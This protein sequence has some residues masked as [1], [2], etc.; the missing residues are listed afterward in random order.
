MLGMQTATA[1]PE[2]IPACPEGTTFNRGFCESEPTIT[3]GAC[4]DGTLQTINGEEICAEFVTT[5]ED[6]EGNVCPEMVGLVAVGPLERAGTFVCDFYEAFDF[7]PGE[8]IC[9]EGTQLNDDVCR[10]RPGNG[11]GA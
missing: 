4:S 11:N 10:A 3:E 6:V 1:Q 5:I 7:I 9:P 8:A 2:T